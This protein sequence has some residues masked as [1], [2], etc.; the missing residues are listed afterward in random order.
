M[1]ALIS[2]ICQSVSIQETEKMKGSGGAKG[3]PGLHFDKVLG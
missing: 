2:E 3:C 1:I